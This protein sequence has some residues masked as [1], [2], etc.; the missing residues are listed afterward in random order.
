M[1]SSIPIK[2]I[3]DMLVW[4]A[5]APLAFM[6][7]L[8]DP[9]PSYIHTAIIY[10][11]AGLPIKASLEFSFALHLQSWKRLGI[12]DLYALAKAIF[13][14]VVLL[15]AL[16]FFLQLA[17]SIP[18]SIPIIEGALGMLLLGG[19]RL[20]ARILY[21]KSLTA[22]SANS[23]GL[24]RVLI[25]GAGDAGTMLAREMI[26]HPESGLVPVGFLDDD[27]KKQ[28]KR[29][30][31]IPVM[32]RIEDLPY[33]A[34]RT[35]A[36]E[37]LVAIPSASGKVVRR[38]VD[39]AQRSGL[40]YRIVP[41]MYEILSG[42]VSISQIRDVDVVDLLRREPVRLDMGEIAGYLEGRTILVTGAGGSI[43]SEIVRQVVR[44]KP[45]EII[46]LGRGE[47]SLYIL[48]RELQQS[49]PN[50][51]WSTIIAD[52]R[53][54][55]KIEYIF[56]RYRPEVVF[57]AAAHKHV[58]MMEENPDEAVFNNVIGTKN[59]VEVSFANNVERFVNISTDKAVN[60][61]SIMGASKRVAEYI[62]QIV[63]EQA[64]ADK[65]FVSVRFGNVLG[66][67][68]SVIPLFKQQIEKG[69]PVTITH[70]KMAR[71]FMTIPEAAQ[72]VLQ[73]GSIGNNGVVYVL[74][75]GEPIK[76]IDLA[77][78]LIRL[79]GLVPEEDIEIAY[80]GM[81]PGEK[82]FEELLTSEEGMEASKHEKIY[83]A[84]VNVSDPSMIYRKIEELVICA[85][86]RNA[87]CI[88]K[89][90]KDLIPTYEPFVH[91]NR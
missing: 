70:P 53:D 27:A 60:P 4:S 34:V 12:R 64:G 24:R 21:E 91:A 50:L 55:E 77:K 56:S 8:D 7:R 73:A 18:R 2:F 14:G 19:V 67:R 85:R 54:R 28:R 78:D 5:A 17:P 82:L 59:I 29:F 66:S 22:Y 25:V 36:D 3:V 57:H 86:S 9:W 49:W 65:A 33:I 15:S 20:L 88:R 58:P 71:Y 79:S 38:V 45:R 61:T 63:A 1:M 10:T 48:E 6:L 75:M 37:V 39:L 35:R 68:G 46:L 26:R 51:N 84:K 72:L 43:G 87:D 41:G 11:I 42:K 74:D 69:G 47:N 23:K 40:R 44:F 52:V 83:I 16:S 90:F 30:I 13:T 32:G 81:R 80:T 31:G 76:I 89:V 62:V